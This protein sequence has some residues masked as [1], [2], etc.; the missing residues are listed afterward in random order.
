MY[1][2]KQ[3]IL[4]LISL[5]AIAPYRLSSSFWSFELSI[6]LASTFSWPL[7]RNVL[8]RMVCIR[9]I[10]WRKSARYV[11][12]RVMVIDNWH[13]SFV[14]LGSSP[15]WRKC[16][17]TFFRYFRALF[18]WS[19]ASLFQSD[20]RICNFTETLAYHKSVSTFY[21]CIARI[22][23]IRYMCNTSHPAS[24]EHL[25]MFSNHLTVIENVS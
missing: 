7:S 11:I 4:T 23:L 25:E 2:Y 20:G 3:Y 6:T 18:N 15:W 13:T 5:L 14:L 24:K 12:T 21:M 17:V 10:N 8:K 9:L 19:S 16:R 22:N 1:M